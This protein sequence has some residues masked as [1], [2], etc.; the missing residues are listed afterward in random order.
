MEQPLVKKSVAETREVSSAFNLENEISKIKVPIPLLELLKNRAS[1]EPFMKLLHPVAPLSDI[2][3]LQDVNP[4][5]YLGPHSIEK[6]DDVIPPFYI[7]LNIHDKLL[8]KFLLDSGASHNLMPE[9]VM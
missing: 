6:E 4:E 1:K 2:V 3:N 8:H 9:R 7:T 5:L